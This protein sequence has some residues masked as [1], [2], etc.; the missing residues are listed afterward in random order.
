MQ[1]TRRELCSLLS[2][3]IPAAFALAV[4]A[5]EDNSLPSAAFAFD[6]MPVHNANNG[7][8]FRSAMRGKLATGEG[9]EVHE[10][11]LPPGTSPHAPHRHRHSELWLIREGEL[12]LTIN[13]KTY[14]LS[15]GGVGFVRSDEEHG[16]RNVGKSTANY[17]VVAVGPGVEVQT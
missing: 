7:A 16:I 3:I 1:F 8:E 14:P 15:A 11:A 17:F 5:A 4:H 9:L 12:E 13:G 6:K 10:S 2:G